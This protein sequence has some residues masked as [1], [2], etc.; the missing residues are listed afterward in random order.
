MIY[1]LSDPAKKY[2]EKKWVSARLSDT[3]ED[4][5]PFLNKTVFKGV[6]KG[7]QEEWHPL[8]GLIHI[9]ALSLIPK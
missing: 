5:L 2:L 6:L 7:I 9:L 1:L 4:N 3:G 8:K